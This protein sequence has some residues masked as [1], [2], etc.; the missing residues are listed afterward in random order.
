MI[1][2]SKE[3]A[4]K[5][6]IGQLNGGDIVLETPIQRSDD[7][8]TPEQKS[9]FIESI[10]KGYPV[11]SFSTVMFKNE[12]VVVDGKQRSTALKQFMNGEF[13]LDGCDDEQLNGKYYTLLTDKQRQVFDSEKILIIKCDDVTDAEMASIFR[14]LNN[15]TSLT[16]IQKTKGKLGCAVAG[17]VNEIC[18]L[19][20]FTECTKFTTKQ[21]REDAQAE[22]L[23]QGIVLLEGCIKDSA[24]KVRYWKNISKQYID[25][26]SD[27]LS[28]WS[29][30]RLVTVR[31]I[32]EYV[33]S[34]Q[35]KK[36]NKSLI[37]TLM[38]MGAI[39]KTN[40][41]SAEDWDKYVNKVIGSVDDSDEYKEYKSSGNV[42]RHKTCGRLNILFETLKSECKISDDSMV[43]LSETPME[44]KTK[45]KSSGKKKDVKDSANKQDK[46]ENINNLEN[47]PHEDEENNHKSLTKTDKVSEESTNSEAT[48]DISSEPADTTVES[49]AS[50]SSEADAEHPSDGSDGTE[51]VA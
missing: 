17:W 35:N 46:D 48:G 28:T 4:V 21:L 11:P 5:D 31:E 42:S 41:V 20:L 6:F 1:K 23:V 33:G 34:T 9:L 47:D 45:S 13:E 2:T 10:I 12:E 16:S 50:D 15:G 38:V 25:S 26:F 8:W 22:A 14:R 30:D 18:K 3:V 40:N 39:A 29:A 43:Y 24:G 44:P 49:S 32:V 36:L 19:R 37:P 51:E 27:E 7:K